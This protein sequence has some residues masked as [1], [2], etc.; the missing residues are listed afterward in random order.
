FE[1]GIGMMRAFIDEWQADVRVRSR[2]PAAKAQKHREIWCVFQPHTYTRTK[3]LLNE[4]AQ[5]LSLADHVVLADIYAARETN[6][7]GI[8]STDLQAKILE[9]GVDCSYFSTFDEIEIFLLGKCT[10][11]DLLITMGAGDIYK[12]GDHLLGL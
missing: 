12:V 2:V 1:D 8:S 11:G 10:K 5:T 6:V 4:F 7:S 9:F 3:A